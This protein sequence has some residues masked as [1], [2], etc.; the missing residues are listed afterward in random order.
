MQKI[1]GDC[2][3]LAIWNSKIQAEL[4]RSTGYTIQTLPALPQQYRQKPHRYAHAPT[5]SSVSHITAL[6]SDEGAEVLLRQRPCTSARPLSDR[7]GLHHASKT[8]GHRLQSPV[9]CMGR[10]R[11]GIPLSLHPR[12]LAPCAIPSRDKRTLQLLRMAL[13]QTGVAPH[14]RRCLA[15]R[16]PRTFHWAVARPPAAPHVS[17][18]VTTMQHQRKG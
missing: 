16:A 5:R 8:H 7:H 15:S 12:P 4:Y 9:Y 1:L 17:T 3:G 13:D 14:L 18:E 10:A 6:L 2:H 11:G